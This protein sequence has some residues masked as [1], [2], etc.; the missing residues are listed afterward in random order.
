MTNGLKAGMV[1][2]GCVLATVVVG[3]LIFAATSGGGSPDADLAALHRMGVPASR[4]E[5][6]RQSPYDSSDATQWYTEM[7]RGYAHASATT[8]AAYKQLNMLTPPTNPAETE[9]DANQLRV[10]YEPFFIGAEARSWRM[11]PKSENDR[12]VRDVKNMADEIPLKMAYADSLTGKLKLG[13]QELHA[14]DHFVDQQAANPYRFS[15]SHERVMAIYH[16]LISALRNDPAALQQIEDSLSSS[17]TDPDVRPL[18]EEYV[19]FDQDIWNNP[20]TVIGVTKNPSSWQQFSDRWI[21]PRLAKEYALKDLH[22]W[23][24]LFEKLKPGRLS[25]NE[26]RAAMHELRDQQH[27]HFARNKFNSYFSQLS[28]GLANC[29]YIGRDVIR[30]Q[31]LICSCQ[32]MIARAKTGSFPSSLPVYGKDSEDPFTGK[33]LVY[34]PSASGF[35]LYSLGP[36]EKDDGGSGGRSGVLDVVESF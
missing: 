11:P 26:G 15:I 32:L 24:L 4:K 29:D 21:E 34:R 33:R 7:V 8:F 22:M 10:M 18:F 17:R 16:E 12:F 3:A 19:I 6:E 13:L 9:I 5:M 1:V 30:R 20:K 25:W 23:R 28:Y 2:G 27:Y 31:L 35:L 36:N 14:A